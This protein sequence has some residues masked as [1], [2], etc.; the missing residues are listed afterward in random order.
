M[1]EKEAKGESGERGARR[2]RLE[3]TRLGQ[4]S[5]RIFGVFVGRDCWLFGTGGGLSTNCEFTGRTGQ[6]R[7][8]VMPVCHGPRYRTIMF[9]SGDLEP[10]RHVI[11]TGIG[12]HEAIGN[13]DDL[14]IF[15]Q[16][17]IKTTMQ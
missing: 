6:D 3:L 14:S 8:L 5:R 1:L 9:N 17:L 2:S 7:T 15:Q 12:A 16:P 4:S 10:E 11:Q 13:F